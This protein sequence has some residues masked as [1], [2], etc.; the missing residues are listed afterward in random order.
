MI[1]NQ[2]PAIVHEIEPN[3][4]RIMDE[5][6]APYVFDGMPQIRCTW[7]IWSKVTLGFHTI[8]HHQDFQQTPEKFRRYD[9][10]EFVIRDEDN[11]NVIKRCQSLFRLT[12]FWKMIIISK[13]SSQ[14]IIF[15]LLARI[16][17]VVRTFG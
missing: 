1:I 6:K 11:V 12:K 9:K 7:L 16:Y 4:H 8:N 10:L 15:F 13:E 3:H 2:E 17:K 5:G 14:L